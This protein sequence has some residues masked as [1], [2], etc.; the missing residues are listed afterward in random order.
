MEETKK[1]LEY[2]GKTIVNLNLK[3]PSNKTQP[4]RFKPTTVIG[5][6][7]YTPPS[8]SNVT[9]NSDMRA[10]LVIHYYILCC[11]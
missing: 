7:Y 10:L 3:P 5:E 8:P 1:N 9:T 4:P 11:T 6:W 2:Q